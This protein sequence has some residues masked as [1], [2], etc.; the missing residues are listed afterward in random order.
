MKNRAP[1]RSLTVAGTIL[2]GALVLGAPPAEAADRPARNGSRQPGAVRRHLPAAR[3][4][5]PTPD[6]VLRLITCGGAFDR[7]ARSYLDNVIGY[8]D[9]LV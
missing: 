7:V 3:I 4:W 8:A 5:R 2:F 1:A 6:P 9:R